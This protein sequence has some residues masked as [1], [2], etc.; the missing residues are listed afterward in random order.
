MSLFDPRATFILVIFLFYFFYPIFRLESLPVT[1]QLPAEAPEMNELFVDAAVPVSLC[2]QSLTFFFCLFH[3]FIPFYRCN[4]HQAPSDPRKP[5]PPFSPGSA[6][7]G[8]HHRGSQV[9]SEG[10]GCCHR[11]GSGRSRFGLAVLTGC[12]HSFSV[13][14]TIIQTLALKLKTGLLI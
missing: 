14:V 12:N 1:V 3:K 2:C 9:Q 7:R 8:I 5:R 11:Q 6:H 4:S 10:H 13:T